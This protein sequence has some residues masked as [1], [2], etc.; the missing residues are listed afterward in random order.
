MMDGFQPKCV[1]M[2]FEIIRDCNFNIVGCVI[3][4]ITRLEA[5]ERGWRRQLI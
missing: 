1:I 2:T 5:V 4:G 3:G